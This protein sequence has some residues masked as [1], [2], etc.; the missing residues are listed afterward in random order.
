MRNPFTISRDIEQLEQERDA[1]KDELADSK[2]AWGQTSS[3]CIH[4]TR[5]LMFATARI[6]RQRKALRQLNRAYDR[7]RDSNSVLRHMLEVSEQTRKPNIAV[8]LP[9]DIQPWQAQAFAKAVR[10]P[11]A[12]KDIDILLGKAGITLVP[13]Q[14]TLLQRAMD[15]KHTKIG[16]S[17]GH[18][19]N[20]D[21]HTMGAGRDYSKPMNHN[22]VKPCSCGVFDREPWDMAN[23]SLKGMSANQ[24]WLDEVA[25]M[26]DEILD[27]PWYRRAWDWLVVHTSRAFSPDEVDRGH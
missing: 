7:L 2:R 23:P 15:E 18:S 4:V 13:W 14:R 24:V 17:A 9:K 26:Y 1:L 16:F 6:T 27:A 8:T 21:A 11:E 10:E 12:A 3:K 25:Q 5:E 20:S 19:L 22:H